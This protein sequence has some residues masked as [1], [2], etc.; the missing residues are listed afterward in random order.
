MT[1]V[2]NDLT[3]A[4]NFHIHDIDTNNINFFLPYNSIRETSCPG[5]RC[6]YTSLVK[7]NRCYIL[8]QQEHCTASA[9][10]YTQRGVVTGGTKIAFFRA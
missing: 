8:W 5:F 6:S 7:K 4:F 2:I 9:I 1:I 3:K 10:G